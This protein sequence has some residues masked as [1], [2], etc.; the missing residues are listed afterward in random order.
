MAGEHLT[1]MLIVYLG[2]I[3]SLPALIG[4]ADILCGGGGPSYHEPE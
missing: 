1:L 3:F 4:F 2:I